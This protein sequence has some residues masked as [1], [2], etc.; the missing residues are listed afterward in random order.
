MTQDEAKIFAIAILN[1]LGIKLDPYIGQAEAFR[2]Y[3]RTKVTRWKR[4][5]RIKAVRDTETSRKRYSRIALEE[6]N[7]RNYA[8]DKYLLKK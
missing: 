8:L 3:G 6:E 7:Q 5:G 2:L 4:D 1:E